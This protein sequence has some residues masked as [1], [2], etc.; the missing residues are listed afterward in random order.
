MGV[1]YYVFN[2]VFKLYISKFD[3]LLYCRSLKDELKNMSIVRYELTLHSDE[4]KQNKKLVCV[5][6][7][8]NK[9]Q[10]RGG[11]YSAFVSHY[12]PS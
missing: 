10:Q 6:M 5:S 11:H 12:V 8:K 4:K 1:F 7:C 9:Q 3:V 2:A